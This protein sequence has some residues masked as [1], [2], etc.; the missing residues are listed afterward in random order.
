MGARVAPGLAA[1]CNQGV[2]AAIHDLGLFN[3]RVRGS[4]IPGPE[5]ALDRGPGRPEPRG[6]MPGH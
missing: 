4:R 5:R 3:K 1:E 2:G 6:P